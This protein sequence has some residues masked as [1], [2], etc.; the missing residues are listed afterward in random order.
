MRRFIARRALKAFSA[1]YDYDVSY[2]N[3][4][5]NV[6]PAAFF[7]FAGLTKRG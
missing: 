1:R 6:S 5:L 7:K 3:H 4:M 2:M